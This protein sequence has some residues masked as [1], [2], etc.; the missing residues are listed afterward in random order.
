VGLHGYNLNFDNR[1]LFNTGTIVIDENQNAFLKTVNSTNGFGSDGVNFFKAPTNA[2]TVGDVITAT[3]ATTTK[4][5]APSGGSGGSATNA[6]ATVSS[7]GVAIT[8]SATNLDF[9]AKSGAVTIF[10]TNRSGHADITI[11]SSTLQ[12]FSGGSA[13]TLTSSAAKYSNLSG[14]CVAVDEV[15]VGTFFKNAITLTNLNVMFSAAGTG[16]NVTVTI[17][18]N[19]VASNLSVSTGGITQVGVATA[20]TTHGI[21]L[22]ANQRLTLELTTN[23]NYTPNV[24]WSL[25]YY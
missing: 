16:T 23:T 5:A 18:T 9:W 4:F 1:L 15:S 10:Q 13:A 12:K 7:N 20:D 2:P 3:S 24:V 14:T 21:V 19:G 25:E 22:P 8:T 17:Y 6:I 11:G